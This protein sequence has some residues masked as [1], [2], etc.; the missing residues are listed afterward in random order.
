MLILIGCAYPLVHLLSELIQLAM[1][2]SSGLPLTV[3]A[4]NVGNKIHNHANSAQR[5]WTSTVTG[6]ATRTLRDGG[7][8]GQA[9]ERMLL[10]ERGR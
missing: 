4:G 3:S 1:Q 6:G 7:R 9:A 8:P 10:E 5:W 2:S